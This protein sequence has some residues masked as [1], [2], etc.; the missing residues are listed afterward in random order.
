MRTLW[1]QNTKS[2]IELKTEIA[3]QDIPSVISLDNRGLVVIV[4]N[5]SG[6]KMVVIIN[7]VSI[8]IVINNG[9]DP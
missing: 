6:P 7:S 5:N 3:E 2:R 8:M 1:I 4:I 9:C